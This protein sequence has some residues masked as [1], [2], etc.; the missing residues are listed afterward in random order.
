VPAAY[1]KRRMTLTREQWS[2]MFGEN[3]LR[4]TQRPGS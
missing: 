2:N 4:A 1:V 3:L